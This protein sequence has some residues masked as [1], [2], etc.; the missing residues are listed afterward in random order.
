MKP[1]GLKKVHL[2]NR[3]QKKNRSVTWNFPIETDKV[4]QHKRETTGC[5]DAS[6]NNI[7]NNKSLKSSK[8]FGRPD[9]SF[10]ECQRNA[11]FAEFGRTH[12]NSN[13][14]KFSI[15]GGMN[16]HYAAT[17]HN[18]RAQSTPMHHSQNKNAIFSAASMTL[19]NNLDR[20]KA[21]KFA[22]TAGLTFH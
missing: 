16:K 2:A 8:S 15:V 13:V 6:R 9:A 5:L 4:A 21:R 7:P 10:F 18:I 17:S 22:I 20:D 14:P 3:L 1:K 12:A 19:S 11:T